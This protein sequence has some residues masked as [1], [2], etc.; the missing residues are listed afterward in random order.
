[1]ARTLSDTII[2]SMIEAATRLAAGRGP[3]AGSG[4]QGQHAGAAHAEAGGPVGQ[5]TGATTDSAA[6]DATPAAAQGSP[7]RGADEHD[8]RTADQIGSDFQAIYRQI[9]EV[10][11]ISAE[12]ETKAV[13]F[14]PR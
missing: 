11:K 2:I 14:A 6:K 10:V 9:E 8:T 1:M 13:G 12:Q 5:E 7:R 4:G 3:I